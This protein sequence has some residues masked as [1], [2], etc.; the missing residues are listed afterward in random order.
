ME[1]AFATSSTRRTVH[2]SH[3]GLLLQK[4]AVERYNKF[5]AVTNARMLIVQHVHMCD[6]V[7]LANTQYTHNL[8]AIY[9][10]YTYIILC[11]GL[12]TRPNQVGAISNRQHYRQHHTTITSTSAAAAERT[13]GDGLALNRTRRPRRL[14]VFALLCMRVCLYSCRTRK[15]R[16]PRS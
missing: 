1:T 4:R 6:V 8:S 16:Y 3:T 9:M 2:T 12:Y 13:C 5:G 11:C 14:F 15:P 7:H 10:L